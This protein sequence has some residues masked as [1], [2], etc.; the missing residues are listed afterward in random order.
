MDISIVKADGAFNGGAAVV[1]VNGNNKNIDA[2]QLTLNYDKDNY[3]DNKRA[4]AR[5]QAMNIISNAWDSD[6][7]K[8]QKIKN[9]EEQRASFAEQRADYQSKMKDIDKERE[10][11]MDEY[12]VDKDSSEQKDLELLE[13]YQR[14]KSG[15]SYEDFSDDEISRLKELQNEPL[16]EYQKRSLELSS[17]RN[18]LDMEVQR[19]DIKLEAVNMNALAARNEQAASQDMTDAKDL[20]GQVL[21][22]AERDVV[23]EAVNEAKEN[24][25]EKRT[26]SEEKAEEAEEKK[27]ETEAADAKTKAERDNEDIVKG[28]AESESIELNHKID[29]QSTDNVAEAQKQIQQIIKENNLINEDIKGIDIDLNF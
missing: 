28:E 11:L 18:G 13:K 12:G 27:A 29:S 14:N 10:Q 1:G 24:I 25:D 21:D 16:T 3:S 23:L 15:T 17:L 9:L 20:A 8:S 2:R 19:I 5:R 26:E 6:T 4:N 22:A 7:K